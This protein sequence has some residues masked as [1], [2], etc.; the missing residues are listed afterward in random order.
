MP[1]RRALLALVALL[2]LAGCA[3]TAGPGA[4]PTSA[5]Q[6]TATTVG[7]PTASPGPT[8]SPPST[9]PP[10]EIVEYDDL[11]PATQRAFRSAVENGSVRRDATA[12]DGLSPGRDAYVGYDGT[13]YA[14]DWG[15]PQLRAIYGLEAV[16]RANVSSIGPN[17]TVVAYGNLSPTAQRIFDRA[18]DGSR[19]AMYGHGAF[20]E[21]FLERHYVE[22]RGR[23]YRPLVVHA[24]IPRVELGV[25]AVEPSAGS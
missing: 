6:P 7:E 17:G 25:H 5:G 24:D 20:P 13:V 19:P 16:E 21:P 4:T 18:R 8:E 14:L 2:V 15:A 23:Y 3:G 1:S 10:R 11:P 9:V 12:F 22:Y